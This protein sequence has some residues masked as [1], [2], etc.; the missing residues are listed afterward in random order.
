MCGAVIIWNKNTVCINEFIDTNNVNINFVECY[1]IISAFPNNGKQI[2]VD[3][4]IKHD[5]ICN[6]I[7]FV[8][9]KIKAE[10]KPGKYFYK[11]F[12]QW[13]QQEP[14]NCHKKWENDLEISIEDWHDIYSL[15]FCLTRYKTIK[16]FNINYC[17]EFC[18]SIHS[19]I[20]VDLKKQNYVLFV[21]KLN[22]IY[23]GI[24]I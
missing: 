14:V 12:I 17:T 6:E 20:N 15:S 7:H 19:Y 23:F 22:K 18:M 11:L 9:A 1:Y 3:E 10:N 8:V 2:T 5:R 24:V 13:I 4:T 16:T 21:W